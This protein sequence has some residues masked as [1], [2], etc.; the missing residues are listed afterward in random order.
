LNWRAVLRGLGVSA[1]LSSLGLVVGAWWVLT[2]W[3]P[4]MYLAGYLKFLYFFTVWAGAMAAG[5][6]APRLPWRHGAAIGGIYSC[7]LLFLKWLLVPT[8]DFDLSS[9][10]LVLNS[11]LMGSFAGVVG[12][13]LRKAKI[14]RQKLTPS[15]QKF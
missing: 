10:A 12:Q 15:L 1:I 13:N 3:E 5:R 9:G 14:R 7:L 2:L 6:R 8:L 11:L 4:E